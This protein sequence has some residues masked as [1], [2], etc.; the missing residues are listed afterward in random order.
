[1]PPA[2]EEIPAAFAAVG[3]ARWVRVVPESGAVRHALVRDESDG[4]TL[5]GDGVLDVVDPAAMDA[6]MASAERQRR[7]DYD[8][9]PIELRPWDNPDYVAGHMRF[10]CWDA[11]RQRAAALSI[12]GGGWSGGFTPASLPWNDLPWHVVRVVRRG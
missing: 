9:H 8:G 4:W 10:S 2:P 1:L 11:D 5:V 12:V 7:E 6:Q 3:F